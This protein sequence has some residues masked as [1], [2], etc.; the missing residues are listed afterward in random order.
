[1]EVM[2]SA[3]KHNFWC[4]CLN[5]TAQITMFALTSKNQIIFEEPYRMSNFHAY[6][7][8]VFNL[9]IRTKNGFVEVYHHAFSFERLGFFS[10]RKNAVLLVYKRHVRTWIIQILFGI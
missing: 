7:S 8:G 10:S 1:M 4:E 6:C 2:I 3:H 9:D 5:H